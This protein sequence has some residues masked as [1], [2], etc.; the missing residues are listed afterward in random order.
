MKRNNILPR[1]YILGFAVLASLV[2][3]TSSGQSTKQSNKLIDPSSK[4]KEVFSGGEGLRH[5]IY[6]YYHQ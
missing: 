5:S 3:F 6:A 4:L 1:G 2:S